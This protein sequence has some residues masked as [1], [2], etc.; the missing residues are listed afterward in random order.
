[1]PGGRIP[2]PNV[3]LV[4]KKHSQVHYKPSLGVQVSLVRNFVSICLSL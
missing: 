4:I 2:L 3:G 1:M